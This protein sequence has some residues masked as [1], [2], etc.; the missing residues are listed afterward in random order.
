MRKLL[1][2]IGIA[3]GNIVFVAVV[4]LWL[5]NENSNMANQ[6]ETMQSQIAGYG[7]LVKEV[8]TYRQRAP[9][10]GQSLVQ[11][12]PDFFYLLS[13]LILDRV[14]IKDLSYDADHGQIK[15]QGYAVDEGDIAQFVQKL[16]QSNYLS[17]VTLAEMSKSSVND[18]SVYSFG[19]SC[20]WSGS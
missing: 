5:E 1:F 11:A 9:A 10:P 3:L 6:L 17:H 2:I 20:N 19:I 16:L 15:L 18:A 4:S 8:T 12:S 7:P 14:W 13:E